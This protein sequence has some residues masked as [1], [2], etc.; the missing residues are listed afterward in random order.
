MPLPE[1]P[2]HPQA[3]LVQSPAW[4]LLFSPGFLV[5]KVLLYPPR[6]YFPVLCKFWQLYVVAN[7]NLLQEGLCHTQVC[8]TQSPCPCGRPLLTH[9]P[10]GDAQTE[11]CL[12]LCRIPGPWCAEGSF[13]PSEHLWR[14]WGLILNV[15]LLLLPCCSSFSFALGYLFTA[16]SVPTVLLGF[17]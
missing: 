15:N 8:C 11:F 6:V 9:T 16:A 4:S 12:N 17:L 3:S 2:R 1:T 5:H 14:E 10:T 13:E 7:G